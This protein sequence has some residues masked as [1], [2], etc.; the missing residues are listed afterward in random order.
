MPVH[1]IQ[2]QDVILPM[3]DVLFSGLPKSLTFT[4]KGGYTK[5]NKRN[6]GKCSCLFTDIVHTLK[7]P[8]CMHSSLVGVM[9]RAIGPSVSS[10]GGWS[11][12]CRNIGSRKASV[13]PE[14]VLAMP[15]TSLPFMMA[16]MAW[17]W[18]NRM[19]HTEY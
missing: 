10:R 18:R 17:L 6:K 7:L 2:V 12:T 14:P 1:L 5:R 8:I 13:F 15:M 19:P 3:N 9:M 4:Y 16:G 11:T